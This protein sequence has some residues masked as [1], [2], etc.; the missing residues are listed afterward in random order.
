M[1]IAIKQADLP[2]GL[3]AEA[4][5][6]A[7]T[8]TGTP[9]QILGETVIARH[10]G[11]IIALVREW[12]GQ[13]YQQ[14]KLTGPIEQ[15]GEGFDSLLRVPTESEVVD[16]DLF[17][18]DYDRL[19]EVLTGRAAPSAL[20]MPASLDFGPLD[21][22]LTI[23]PTPDIPNSQAIHQTR[24]AG[25]PIEDRPDRMAAPQAVQEPTKPAARA[26]DEGHDHR[27]E[28]K[29][30]TKMEKFAADAVEEGR[31]DLAKEA[32]E[33]LATASLP[34]AQQYAVLAGC[35]SDM[36]E[37][38]PDD[39]WVRLNTELERSVTLR[40]VVSRAA[41]LQLE[42][43]G[44]I[45]LASA[46]FA[47]AAGA[48]ATGNDEL[49]HEARR[50]R[51]KSGADNRTVEA[52]ILL[53]TLEHYQRRVGIDPNDNAAATIVQKTRARLAGFQKQLESL[54][55]PVRGPLSQLQKEIVE[56]HAKEG[57]G[58]LKG[59]AKGVL[60]LVGFWLFMRGC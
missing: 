27:S 51:K 17:G 39:A 47:T 55:E 54:A 57:G 19:T 32:F 15:I 35:M 20:E 29:P 6:A 22:A 3:S 60:V 26:A 18:A 12:G 48:A 25:E 9:G 42:R 49:L 13:P 44:K 43:Q 37:H 5:Q 4:I 23:D 59:I 10:N 45:I 41:G 16:M 1:Y 14:L 52:A 36:L 50:L 2:A 31:F 34:G 46:A 11:R 53:A 58:V 7:V 28:R 40:S 38:R 21:D 33:R 30:L 24:P 56:R 8:L